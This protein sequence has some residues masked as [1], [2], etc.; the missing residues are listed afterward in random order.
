MK[1]DYVEMLSF[2]FRR[3]HTRG[4]NLSDKKR[5]VKTAIVEMARLRPE[6]PWTIIV[7]RKT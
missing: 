3:I 7:S 4:G 2:P 6:G 1:V 5:K